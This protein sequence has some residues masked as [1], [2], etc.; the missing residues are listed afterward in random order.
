MKIHQKKHFFILLKK[1]NRGISKFKSTKVSVFGDSFAFCRYVNDDKTW[2]S[3]IEKKIK[4]NVKNFGVGNYG[5]DQSYLK[6]LKYK[7][8]FKKIKLSYL[9]LFLKQ[10]LELILTGSI[11][12]NLEIYMVLNQS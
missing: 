3:F 4:S 11:T 8:K 6:Y 12:G 7:K 2:Q 10:L 1:G 9:I 5:L